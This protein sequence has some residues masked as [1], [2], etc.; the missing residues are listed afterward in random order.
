MKLNFLLLAFLSFS[1]AWAHQLTFKNYLVM[2]EALAS[3]NFAQA[4]KAH[5]EICEKELGHY[6]EQYKDCEKKFKDIK[7]V[8][9]SFKQLSQ[10]FIA[11]GDKTEMKK[12]NLIKAECPMAK[13]QWIQ[14]EGKIKNPYY[15]SSM[16]DC[17]SKI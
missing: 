7:E 5:H 3:D 13:A 14:S 16:L 8:R 15:G 4:I 1:S 11:E 17:G 12:M 6:K 2:Q 9:E 10:T